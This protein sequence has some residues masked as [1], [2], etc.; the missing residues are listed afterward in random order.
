MFCIILFPEMDMPFFEQ[1]ALAMK[2]HIYG[3]LDPY[4]AVPH[5]YIDIESSPPDFDTLT[6]SPP[7]YE[8]C[9]R[10]TNYTQA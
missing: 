10:Q 4:P 8:E 5:S 9:I 7:S 6:F 3:S 2:G 1:S